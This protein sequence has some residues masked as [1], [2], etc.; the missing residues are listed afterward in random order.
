MEW[1]SIEDEK[2]PLNLDI[3]FVSEREIHHGH[4]EYGINYRT[5]SGRNKTGVKKWMYLPEL[6]R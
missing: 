1:I 5:K 2:P 3:L 4:C 6:L